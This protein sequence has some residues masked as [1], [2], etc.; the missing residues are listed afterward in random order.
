MQIAKNEILFIYNSS[1]LQDR[2]ALGYAKSLPDHII[3]EVD[4]QRNKFTELQVQQIAEMLD[5]HPA[6]LIDEKSDIYKKTYSDVELT[7][8]GALKAMASKPQLMK[9][10]IALYNDNARAI[11]SPFEVIKW[12]M[13]SS[14]VKNPNQP[15]PMS[16]IQHDKSKQ[17]FYADLG[18]DRMKLEYTKS[19]RAID[20]TSTFVPPSH[21]NQGLG[22]QLVKAGLDY[23]I[24]NKLS[25][26]ATCPF[27]ATVIRNHPQYGDLLKSLNGD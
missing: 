5:V 14:T 21:R 23:A 7:R 16:K 8:K 1:D 13:A 2:Q 15:Q 25:V 11:E 22:G 27:V 12:Q 6:G 18:S 10:P 4:L 19:G 24:D 20:F 17:L 9:T 26:S 3:K